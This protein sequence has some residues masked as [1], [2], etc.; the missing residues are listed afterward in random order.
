MNHCLRTHSR[1][2]VLTQRSSIALRLGLLGGMTLAPR[3]SDSSCQ[4]LN[5]TCRNSINFFHTASPQFFQWL[6]TI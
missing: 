1:Y 4:P 5:S 6:H 3:K 2:T